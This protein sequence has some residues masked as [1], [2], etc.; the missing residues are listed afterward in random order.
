MVRILSVMDC[1]PGGVF[2]GVTDH[3]S[4]ISHVGLALRN[5]LASW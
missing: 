3:I 1:H 4:Y 2:L 5:F